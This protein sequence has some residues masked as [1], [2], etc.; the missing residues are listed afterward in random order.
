[1]ANYGSMFLVISTFNLSACT[2]NKLC[3]SYDV[4]YLNCNLEPT[5]INS[6]IKTLLLLDKHEKWLFIWCSFRHN[7]I[8]FVSTMYVL[9]VSMHVCFNIDVR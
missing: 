8:T 1:M 2:Q 3:L 9:V 4:L 5:L 6:F 7:N